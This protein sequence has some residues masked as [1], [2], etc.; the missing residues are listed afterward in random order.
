MEIPYEYRIIESRLYSAR[1]APEFS[2]P[3][4]KSL[5]LNTIVLL[6]PAAPSQSLREF[7]QSENINLVH[8]I[9]ETWRPSHE[10][11]QHHQTWISISEGLKY[12]FDKRNYPLLIIGSEVIRAIIRKLQNWTTSAVLNELNAYSEM[13]DVRVNAGASPI[14]E[15]TRLFYGKLEDAKW[16]IEQVSLEDPNIPVIMVDL[17]EKE[18]R[19]EWVLRFGIGED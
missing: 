13:S 17:P 3:F 18:Y 5:E 12:C 4:I 16:V 11:S 6:D 1:T 9:P 7:V 10:S 19:A 14:L 2:Y 8:L 15:L